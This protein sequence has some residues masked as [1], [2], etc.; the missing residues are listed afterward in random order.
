MTRVSKLWVLP[1]PVAP[2]VEGALAPFRPI[3][4]SILARRALWTAGA[5]QEFLDPQAGTG[6]DPFALL[7]METAVG[8]LLRACRRGESI[9]VYGDYDAD[10]LTAAALL[11]QVLSDLGGR[12][13]AQIP[14][15]FEEGYGLQI[16]AIR[17][18]RAAG[19][20]VV[21]TVDCGIRSLEEA[22]EARALG[23]DLIITDHHHPGPMLPAALAVINPR[24]SGDGYPFKELSGAG[25]ALK[26]AQALCRRGGRPEP[27]QVIDLVALGTVADLVPLAGEN[28]SLVAAGLQQLNARPGSARPLRPGLQALLYVAGLQPGNIDA[29]AIAFALAPRLN[30]VGR[31]RSAEAA[32][33]LLVTTDA[34]EASRLA[35]ALQAA[36]RERQELTRQV[37]EAARERALG[38]EVIPE[39]VFAAAPDF[40]PG[41]VG[42]AAAR[43]MEEC[44]RPVVLAVRGADTSRGSARSIPEFHITQALDACA[45][46]LVRHGGHAAA[47]GFT[48]RTEDLDAFASR[49][50]HVAAERLAGVEFRPKLDIDAEVRFDELDDELMRFLEAMEPCGYGNPRP[51]LLAREVAVTEAR[52]VG[53]DNAHLKLSLAQGRRRMEGIAFRQG[54]RLPGMPRWLDMAFHLERNDYVGV[55]TLQLNVVDI[56]PSGE[57]D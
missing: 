34:R 48:L 19:A 35:G 51:L 28:R 54:W 33:H 24:Q 53:R 2:E 55:Q 41:V 25:L 9:V 10:G 57:A 47:A 11:V 13:E 42:L 52:P 15:R 8:R 29:G 4:R 1:E 18:L 39:L 36:N 22:D 30:A 40:H 26:V 56:R 50:Q 17:Q 49:L 45:D 38:A 21:V 23:L 44:Y 43:L 3:E 20:G 46:L 32:Y 5:A 16:E 31:L 37:V 27:Q 7:G 12:V 14:N 6:H